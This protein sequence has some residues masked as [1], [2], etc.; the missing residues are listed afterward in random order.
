MTPPVDIPLAARLDFLASALWR[1]I[2]GRPPSRRPAGGRLQLA[3]LDGE[4]WICRDAAGSAEIYA[5]TLRDLGRGL[6]VAMAQDR[7][8]QM[9]MLRRLAGG[10]LAELLGDRPIARS[11]PNFPGPTLLA[12]DRLYR[13]LRMYPVGQQ[14]VDRLSPD[15]ADLLAGFSQG[16]TAWATECPPAHLPPECLLTGTRPAPWMPADSLAVGRL[17]GWMLGLAFLAKPVLS[18]LAA[19]PVLRPM[20]PPDQANA[21]CIAA[22]GP[23]AEAAC[24][25]LLARQALGLAGPGA[26]SNSWA[27]AGRRTASGLPLLC[28]D[29]H[30]VFGLPPL[31]YPVA[32]HGPEHEVIG[33]TIAGLPAVLIGHN[34]KLA[35]GLTA[36]MADD[37]D[38]YR[39]TLDGPGERY[40]RGS[41]WHPVEVVEER[42]RVRGSQDSI[43]ERVPYVRHEGVLCP[44]VPAAASRSPISFRWVGLEPWRGLDALIG[45]NRARSLE[46]FEGAVAEFAL[47]A[48]NVVV[49]DRRGN[50]AYFCAGR[51]PRRPGLAGWPTI[52]DGALPQHAW[53]G[54]LSWSEHPKSVNPPAG[55]LVTANNR[56]A[57]SLPPTIAAGF[58][59][60]PYRATR[61][62]SLLTRCVDARVE[63]MARIQED[64]VSLQAAGILEG[65]LRPVADA[66]RDPRSRQ[67][68]SALLAWDCRLGEESA[69]AA[70]YGLFYQALLQRCMR[71][72]LE[73][74]APGLFSQYLSIL[75]LAVPAVD[76]L[77]LTGASPRDPAGHAATVEDCLLTAWEQA[78]DR[79]GSEPERWR[80]G[81]LHTLT[82]SHG[83]GRTGHRILRGL[84]WLLR[85]NRGPYPRPGDG[86]TVNL[87]AFAL[88]E[89]FNVQ[90]GPAYRQLVDLGTP[91]A[92]RWIIAGGVSGDPRS[93]HYADQIETWRRGATRPMRLRPRAEAAGDVFLRLVPAGRG[94][95]VPPACVL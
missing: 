1:R 29:P 12:V 41:T 9:E 95:C 55:Y 22:D 81:A 21:T 45:M 53:G 57:T 33:A 37:G 50:I 86:M 64:V 31:W 46:E 78:H 82:L 92:S 5:D 16:V 14:E 38:Y 52:L 90:V 76:T 69:P 10:R 36:T 66:L 93:M 8:G 25:D 83:F 67:A 47:P 4:V 94:D 63:D 80:W 6:G 30:L 60:P 13:S 17:I 85:L 89:P 49:A 54:Y 28:N 32:L 2:A 19:D 68:A 61:I 15:A 51:F 72:P 87:G 56:P 74:R 20:L 39:E 24:L 84:A 58:W 70:L 3:G 62:A 40:L 59:E 73:A 18:L 11:R 42:F 44:L 23:P 88:T 48:Q 77:L 71:P 35:W 34:G 79:M 27:L 91:E 7:L 65:V 43:R 26:G 75:H